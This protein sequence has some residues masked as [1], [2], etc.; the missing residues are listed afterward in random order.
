MRILADRLLPPVPKRSV[1]SGYP[2][3]ISST[4]SLPSILKNVQTPEDLPEEFW[5]WLSENQRERDIND[6]GDAED[7]QRELD[8]LLQMY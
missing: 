5:K 7:I 3:T 1:K 6:K 2:T 8:E 4:Q